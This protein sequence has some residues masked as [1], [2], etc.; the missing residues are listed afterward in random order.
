MDRQRLIRLL[1]RS[2]TRNAVIQ[3]G[4]VAICTAILFLFVALTFSEIVSG[5]MHLVF[6]TH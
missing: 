3:L 5:K 6:G 1:L 2:T 4:A